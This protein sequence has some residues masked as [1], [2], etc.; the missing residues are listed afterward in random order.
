MNR[1]LLL[2]FLPFFSLAISQETYH[3]ICERDG[4]TYQKQL[5]CKKLEK[6]IRA[7]SIPVKTKPIVP[8]RSVSSPPT[9]KNSFKAQRL[10]RK[11]TPYVPGAYRKTGDQDET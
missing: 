11:I 6:R 8:T 7:R 2:F 3:S 4:L 1:N 9:P 10:H 5:V